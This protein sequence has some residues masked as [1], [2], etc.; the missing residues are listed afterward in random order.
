[1]RISARNILQGKIKK[2]VSGAVNAE[3]VV[4]LPGGQEV[5]AV[6]TISS[7]KSLGLREGM[8]ACAIIKASNVLLGVE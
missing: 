8:D 1:M 6:V 3:V 4:E 2:I 7:V 5:V